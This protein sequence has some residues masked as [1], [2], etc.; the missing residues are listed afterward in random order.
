MLIFKRIARKIVRDVRK[1]IRLRWARK[2]GLAYVEPN[3]VYWPRIKSGDT[4]VD[5]GCSYEADFSL[6]MI[7]RHGARSFAVDPTRKHRPA[8]AA[9]EA[10]YPSKLFHIPVAIGPS[11]GEL[12]FHE[13]LTH[14][15]G[16]LMADHTNV[17]SDEII[18]YTVR[19]VTLTKLLSELGTD[20][21]A[22]LKLDIEGAEYPLLLDVKASDL[23]PFRQIFIEFH[24][25][26][27]SDFSIND[28]IKVVHRF[29]EMGF[30]SFSLDNIN[31]LFWRE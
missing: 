16:S 15:S 27:V 22:I 31:Y 1:H 12:I 25:F 9:L 30:N 11:N 23:A 6:L 7:D 21:V 29:T 2:V 10:R 19:S 24:H 4:V 26:A 8:L 13:S 3:F 28:T 20:E 5:A 14:E 18:S 17:K